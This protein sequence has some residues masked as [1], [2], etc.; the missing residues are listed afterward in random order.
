MHISTASD[1]RE[2]Y[3]I[4]KYVECAL[5]NITYDN[6]ITVYLYSLH[7]KYF[8]EEFHYFYYMKRPMLIN[9]CVSSTKEISKA[10][11]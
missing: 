4:L 8:N 9:L 3:H 1:L 10:I 7:V 2:E 5:L 11:L 6:C